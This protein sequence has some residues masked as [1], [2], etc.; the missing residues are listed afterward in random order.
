MHHHGYVPEIVTKAF[1]EIEIVQNTL[2][3]I[4]E[5]VNKFLDEEMSE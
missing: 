1:E 4:T 3:D 2:K 5:R